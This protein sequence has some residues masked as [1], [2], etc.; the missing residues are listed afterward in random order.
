MMW[1]DA[2]VASGKSGKPTV[3]F[4]L[5][6]IDSASVRIARNVIRSNRLQSYLRNTFEPA[7][8]DFASDPPPSVGLDSLRN[9]GW[10]LSGLEKSY[11]I[12]KR[13]CIIVIA[14]NKT[15]MDRIVFP[16]KLSS[17]E[18]EQQLNAILNDRNTLH[19][20]VVRFWKDTTNLA[21][22]LK[23]VDM[24]EQRSKYDSVVRHLAMIGNDTKHAVDAKRATLK[25]VLMRLEVESNPQPMKA[26][27]ATLGKDTLSY[28]LLETLIKFYETKHKPDSVVAMY[29]MFYTFKGKRDA[30]M[31]NDEA[32][33]LANSSSNLELAL[34]L[35][36]EAL[37]S[38]PNNPY[39]LD[40]RA[41]AERNMEHYD[42][43]IRD[44]ER[45]IMLAPKKEDKKVFEAQLQ[46]IKSLK[47]KA[48]AE[49]LEDQNEKSKEKK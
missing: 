6:L 46:E 26:F 44:E 24:F 29:D 43:A 3:V 28:G 11:S 7:L 36:N 32:W 12:V 17:I 22:H 23:L 8:N 45:A 48:E 37:Q 18:I 42:D 35:A 5:D 41:V 38:A 39:Y 49:K 1:D 33:F 25:L 10:R 13:P 30:D 19:N 47:Q 34:T 21:L 27:V 31:L 4:D 2:V 20:T 15:E 14:P 40:T 9:L 16:E